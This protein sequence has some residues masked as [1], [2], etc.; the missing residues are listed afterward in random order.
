[1][2]HIRAYMAITA[3]IDVQTTVDTLQDTKTPY[4][5]TPD[6]QKPHGKAVTK[7]RRKVQ[8]SGPAPKVTVDTV[9]AVAEFMCQGM[10]LKYACASLPMPITS[11][12]FLQSIGA[13]SVLAHSYNRK[14]AEEIQ[15]LVASIKGTTSKE[16][17]TG[18]CWFLE[19]LFPEEFSTNRG[20]G[21]V[22]V[23]VQTIVGIG[24]DIRAR[25]SAHVRTG[26]SPAR[27]KPCIRERKIK[28]ITSQ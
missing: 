3:P 24:E 28:E 10:P 5:A 19:R 7:R 8:G 16:M 15:P 14:I 9:Q 2:P 27:E 4:G 26:K 22:T 11:E 13:N 17:P 6:A 23:N 18:T 21:G 12:H 20:K 1:M 25:V